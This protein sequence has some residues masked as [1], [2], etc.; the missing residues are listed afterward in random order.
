[1]TDEAHDA[2]VRD[3]ARVELPVPPSSTRQSLPIPTSQGDE[4]VEGE[5]SRPVSGLPTVA[6]GDAQSKFMEFVHQYI[7]EYI[8]LADQ[9]ATF[10]FTASTALLAFLYR[11]DIS[12]GWAK[13]VMQWNILDIVAFVAMTALAIGALTAVVVVIPRTSGSR[14]GFIFWEAIAEYGTGRDYADEIS[15]LSS[16]TLSQI[17]AEHCF[18]LANVCRRKYRVLRYALWICAVGIAASSIVFLFL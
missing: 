7:R 13:P 11:S 4:P 14:R 10:F 1:M 8:R 9:K 12:A 18:D 6:E 3:P 16:A 5:P 15:V 2:Q 17:K